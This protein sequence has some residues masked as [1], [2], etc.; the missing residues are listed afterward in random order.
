MRYQFTEDLVTGNKLIDAEHQTLIKAADDLMVSISG[1]KGKDAVIKTVKFLSDY[2]K[3]HFRHEEELQEKC[4][5]PDMAIHKAWHRSFEKELQEVAAKLADKGPTSLIVIEL[6]RKMS[7][8]LN[9]IRTK[10]QELAEYI[11]KTAK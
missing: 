8:L 1:G 7:A 2:T 9:H 11:A 5:L 3:T 4:Q 10:D 6:T